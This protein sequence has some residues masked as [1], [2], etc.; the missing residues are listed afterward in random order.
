MTILPLLVAAAV[1]VAVCFIL[2]GV[3]IVVMI[4]FKSRHSMKKVPE[5]EIDVQ[6][7]FNDDQNT[8]SAETQ[9]LSHISHSDYDD[10]ISYQEDIHEIPDSS[11]N[12]HAFPV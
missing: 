11:K 3:A 4:M 5:P 7:Q 12:S 2:L 9:S 6:P 10:D 1:V 8:D